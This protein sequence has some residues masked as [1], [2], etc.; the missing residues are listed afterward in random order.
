MR[1]PTPLL[2]TGP[3]G[4]RPVRLPA[5]VARIVRDGLARRGHGE[6]VVVF[7]DSEIRVDDRDALVMHYR[8][9]G[10]R[11]LVVRLRGALVPRGYVLGLVDLER[12]A[13]VVLLPIETLLSGA[14]LPVDGEPACAALAN[15]GRS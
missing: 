14:D 4:P 15:G 3:A 10:V 1:L 13:R 7:A 12:G 9:I 6:A 2:P 11:E 8:R 5:D